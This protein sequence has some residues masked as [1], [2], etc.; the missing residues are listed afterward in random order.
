[1]SI[2]SI[3]T[4][5]AVASIIALLI[6]K[7]NPETALLLTVAASVTALIAVIGYASGI[8]QAVN[9]IVASAR[10][11]E[12]YIIILLKVIGICLVGEFTSNVCRDAG[13]NSL[14]NNVTL[15]CKLIVTVTALPLYTD[16]F[17]TVVSLLGR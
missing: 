2:I 9:N 3:G 5:A 4:L 6:R 17:N 14:A 8:T 7:T 11:N 12:R 13:S 16:I 1:M 15:A 10:L